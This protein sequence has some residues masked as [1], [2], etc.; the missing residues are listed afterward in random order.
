MFAYL[1]LGTANVAE[2]PVMEGL[3]PIIP[4]ACIVDVPDSLNP[5]TA[6]WDNWFGGSAQDLMQSASKMIFNTPYPDFG[7]DWFRALYLEAGI[8]WLGYFVAT[9]TTVIMMVR[10]ARN[11]RKFLL[12]LRDYA[13]S[14][15]A[16]SVMPAV[17]G[18][19]FFFSSAI[20]DLLMTMFVVDEKTNLWDLIDPAYGGVGW[21][22]WILRLLSIILMLESLFLMLAAVLAVLAAGIFIPLRTLDAFGFSLQTNFWRTVLMGAYVKPLMIFVL[23]VSLRIEPVLRPVTGS[24]GSYVLVAVALLIASAAPY[25]VFHK[26]KKPVQ[27]AVLAAHERMLPVQAYGQYSASEWRLEHDRVQRDR[28]QRWR[29]RGRATKDI[30]TTAALGYMTGGV[31]FALTAA[32][33]SAAKY[34]KSA[35]RLDRGVQQARRFSQARQQ[36]GGGQ[37]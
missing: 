5:I 25:Y 31:S 13:V 28:Q 15:I 9:I 7:A 20:S 32:T 2:T 23:V 35:A 33:S 10:Y 6:F 21:M 17:I 11:W 12:T 1:A 22:S 27:K 30:A 24:M 37:T 19:L 36:R 18:A 16:I 4:A 26:S 8:V 29:D 34:S 3:C 14:L